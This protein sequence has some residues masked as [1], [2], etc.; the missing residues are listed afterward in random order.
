MNNIID[1]VN[2]NADASCLSSDKWIDILK[3]GK[4]S[5]FYKW[6]KLYVSHNKKINIG[7][8]GS[9]ICDIHYYCHEA[10]DLIESNKSIFNV[11]I[12]PFSHDNSLV[13]SRD[14]F[15]INL[16]YGVKVAKKFFSNTSSSFLPPEFMLLSEQISILRDFNFSSIMVNPSRLP[17][18]MSIKIPEI[19][20]LVRGI[21]SSSLACFPVSGLLTNEYLNSIHTYN[22]NKLNKLIADKTNQ[23][24]WRDGE[25]VFLIPDG[26]DR[27]KRWLEAETANRLWVDDLNNIE[28][29]DDNFY[30]YPAHSF[31]AWME[32]FK[33]Y[34]YINRINFLERNLL[35][36][37]IEQTLLWLQVINSDVLS[38]IEKKDVSIDIKLSP[39]SKK[40]NFTIYRTHRAFEGEEFLCFLEDSLLGN[41]SN[42]IEFL[43][44][45]SPHAKKYISRYAVIKE[46]D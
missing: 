6:L 18:Y 39:N 32:E 14:A 27:E 21:N 28:L 40:N 10:I 37:D 36:F 9:S 43:K 25:S 29:K 34:G 2:F 8:I 15:R 33:M 7:I 4:E 31:L 24:L 16:D 17:H 45:L 22:F 1:V 5:K 26:V 12:R 42:L 44:E 11:L 19:P 13:R 46:L 38:S 20:F 23:I 35:N 41:R 30:T 3:G